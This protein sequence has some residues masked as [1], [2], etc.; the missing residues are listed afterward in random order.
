MLAQF[1]IWPL[2]NPH[3]SQDVAAV[4]EVLDQAGVNFQ[5]N[6]MSTTVEGQWQDV[7]NA[8]HACHQAVRAAHTRVLTSI[9]IDD[10]ATRPLNMAEAT[11]KVEARQEEAGST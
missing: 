7:M 11:A 10:D 8:I 3:L 1:S 6:A 9:N 2:D 4:T 5:V